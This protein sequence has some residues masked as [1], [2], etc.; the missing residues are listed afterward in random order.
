MPKCER[1]SLTASGQVTRIVTLGD[2]SF[3]TIT[4]GANARKRGGRG[5]GPL[6]PPVLGQPGL[7]HDVRHLVHRD[8]DEHVMLVMVVEMPHLVRGTGAG[9]SSST[10]DGRR[11]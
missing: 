7:H 4:Q 3:G 5:V 11:G 9:P 2:P 6:D 10:G 1:F 8:T